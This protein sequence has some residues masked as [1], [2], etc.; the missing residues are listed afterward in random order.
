MLSQLLLQS[1][2][3]LAEYWEHEWYPKHICWTERHKMTS[4]QPKT[5]SYKGAPPPHLLLQ[6]SGEHP[7]PGLMRHCFQEK[8]YTLYLVVICSK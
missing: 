5:A 6:E 1:P 3:H 4:A 7:D 2:Q 8:S